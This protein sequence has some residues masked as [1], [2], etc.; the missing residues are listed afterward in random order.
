MPT[1]KEFLEDVIRPTLM[2]INKHSIVAEQLLLGTAIQESRLKYLNQ[3]GG[4]PALGYFQMEPNT[5]DDIWKNYLAYRNHLAAKVCAVGEISTTNLPDSTILA[6]NHRY[7]AAMARVH[8]LRVPATLPL[9]GDINAI[10]GYWKQHYNTYGGKGTIDEFVI[11]WQK[12]GAGA[13]F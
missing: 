2:G 7:A 8:Y 12:A 10:A 6:S 13:L 5:H 9:A 1:P 4:G 3:L 11:N